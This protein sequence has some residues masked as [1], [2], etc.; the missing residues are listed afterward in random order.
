MSSFLFRTPAVTRVPLVRY[1]ARTK[2][3]N[4]IT[5]QL[6][7]DFP[8]YGLKGEIINVLPGLMRNK[9]HPGNGAC[10]VNEKLNMGP[11]IPVVKK[12]VR[13][14]L[15]RLAQ[16]RLEAQ[17]QRAQLKKQEL[18][19]EMLTKDQQYKGKKSVEKLDTQDIEGF[20]FDLPEGVAS[21]GEVIASHGYS[22]ITLEV[23]LDTLRFDTVPLSKE[24]VVNKIQDVVGFSV[25]VGDVKIIQKDV[26]VET[27][28]KAGEYKLVI[29][30]GEGSVTKKIVVQ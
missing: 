2:R 12:E 10:Y 9:L 22:M 6:L 26:A 1:S 28:D 14:Q 29:S 21:T 7:K 23:G 24:Q 17:E 27:C 11:R 20:L 16:E 15:Q 3:E 30:Q 19:S 13:L 5:V 25:P 4:R 18:V 8:Q